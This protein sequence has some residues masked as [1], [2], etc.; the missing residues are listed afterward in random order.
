MAEVFFYHLD[1]K[2]L[3]SILP[4]LVQRGL[5]RGL[6]M[7]VETAQIENLNSLSDALWAA[8]D[9]A[10]IAHG[11]GDDATVNQPLCLCAG[12]ENPNNSTYRFFVE[13]ALPQSLD[14]LERAVILFDGSDERA[15]SSAHDEW[16]KRNAEGHTIS[17]W[18]QNE[19][20]RWE[21]L[22]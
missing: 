15:K 4:Q 3:R 14:G 13:G 1:Q 11:F 22:A 17:Y 16:K 19:N 5:E 2:P 9:V 8:E 10:F 7:V 12:P 20:G 21:N 18:K 6:R